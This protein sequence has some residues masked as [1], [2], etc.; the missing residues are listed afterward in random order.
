[1]GNIFDGKTFDEFCQ[2]ESEEAF[3]RLGVLRMDVDDLG[4]IF[5]NGIPPERATLS[6]YAALS[7]SFDYFFSGY[8]NTIQ[9]AIAPNT[10]FIIYSGGDDLFIVASWEDAVKLAKQIR[11]DF[12]VFTCDNPAFTVS[13]GIAI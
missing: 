7:R 1:G 12:K 13:G 4:Y 11:D 5:Q 3:H 9:Q 8:L 6:R 2:K 10:S